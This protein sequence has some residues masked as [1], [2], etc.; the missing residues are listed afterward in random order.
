M[1]LGKLLRRTMAILLILN[2]RYAWYY[3]C[4]STKYKNTSMTDTNLQFIREKIYE[5][6]SAI[7][8]SLCDELIHLP[9]SIVTAINVDDEGNIWFLCDRPAY[10]LHECPQ[11]FPARLRFFRK[12]SFYHLEVSGRAE[13]VAQDDPGT[14]LH[15]PLLIR[16]NMM[17][18]TYTDMREKKKKAWE[19]SLEKGYRWLLRHVGF[20]RHEKPVL[21]RLQPAN[22]S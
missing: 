8:Y 12:G 1:L 20:T 16:M 18:A 11:A 9:N 22:H 10:P 7:M 2:V 21:A 13:I 15:K 3:I 5:I 19:T 4:F 17:N 6:R 14:D